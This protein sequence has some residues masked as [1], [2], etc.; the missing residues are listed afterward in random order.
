MT[1]RL[2]LAALV[3]VAVVATGVTPGPL[4]AADDPALSV[5]ATSAASALHCAAPVRPG[6][7]PVL[8]VHGTF[9]NDDESWGWGYA[10]ALPR[11]G[12]GTCTVTLPDRAVGDIQVAT[13]YVVAAVR[14]LA[15][16]SGADVDVVT[17]SQG[18]LEARWAL[19]WWPA[20]RDDVDDLVMLAAP[21]HGT[22]VA[23]VATAAGASCPACWQ[24]RP[25][26][27]FLTALNAGDETPGAVSYTSIYSAFD[28]VV[29]EVPPP[30]TS[31]LTGARNILVQDVCAGRPVEHLALLGDGAVFALVVDALAHP[32]PADPARM[33]PLACLQ[34]ILPGADPVAFADVVAGDVA[35]PGLPGD[36]LSTAEPP[37]APYATA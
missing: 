18:G 2:A 24:M 31:A 12:Y 21:N 15:G 3:A 20:V 19:R 9:T 1:R 4:R 23:G 34:T 35:D 29:P 16:A 37:L 33:G 32:G 36:P 26:S 13:E 27:A 11:L 8:L 28:E 30:P 14:T 22:S 7:S 10:K 17:H 5:S 6:H 25:G